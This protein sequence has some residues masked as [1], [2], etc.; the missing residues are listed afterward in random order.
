MFFPS[1]ELLFYFILFYPTVSRLLLLH[2]HIWSLTLPDQPIRTL[3]KKIY[4]LFFFFTPAPPFS[5]LIFFPSLRRMERFHPKIKQ[6]WHIHT[7]VDGQ[8]QI[9]VSSE[10]VSESTPFTQRSSVWVRRWVNPSGQSE[11]R[12]GGARAAAEDTH[13]HAGV[14]PRVLLVLFTFTSWIVSLLI[15]FGN[16]METRQIWRVWLA[17]FEPSAAES[18]FPWSSK[19]WKP[20]KILCFV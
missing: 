5:R 3:N 17:G 8:K 19:W 11:T 14:V 2:C 1:V 13:A 4:I 16:F 18:S 10:W 9:R 6:L 7:S 12:R 20:T 15:Y